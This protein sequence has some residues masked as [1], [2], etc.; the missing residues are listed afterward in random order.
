M[1][2]IDMVFEEPMQADEPK[3]K[4]K[5]NGK[6]SPVIGTNGFM[7]APGDNSNILKHAIEIAYRW[8][9]ID[10]N[11]DEEVEDRIIQYF[12]YCFDNDIKPGVEGMALAIGVDR[13]TI[14]DWEV[15]R[16]R[17]QAGSS[18]SDLIK[19][20]KQI[21]ADYMENLTQNGKIN[22]V[23]AIFLM[24]NHFGYRDQQEINVTAGSALG[25]GL[26]PEEIAKRLPKDIPIDVDYQE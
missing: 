1:E 12:Q 26:S 24:K 25:E 17:S 6:N 9:K 10:L 4:R 21:L 14:W 15:G 2:K 3:K 18:R 16:S 13:K 8:P 5:S 23:T 11:S 19:K 22:P 20:A 7:T